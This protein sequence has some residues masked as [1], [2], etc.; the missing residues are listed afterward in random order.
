MVSVLVYSMNTLALC[1]CKA[2]LHKYLFCFCKSCICVN[3]SLSRIKLWLHSC[4]LS[5]YL[6]PVF[7]PST[8]TK[9]APPPAP[10]SHRRTTSTIAL[11]LFTRCKLF[12]T[13]GVQPLSRWAAGQTTGLPPLGAVYRLISESMRLWGAVEA[14]GWGH[15]EWDAPELMTASVPRGR[16]IWEPFEAW[17]L[18][19]ATRPDWLS[20]KLALRAQ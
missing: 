14:G 2:E 11:L 3:G 20:S 4:Y 9:Q 19:A 8:Q 5:P 15:E 12:P 18:A 16:S 7:S 10:T 6:P 1:K 13:A 17:H